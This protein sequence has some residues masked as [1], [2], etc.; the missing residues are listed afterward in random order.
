MNEN[1]YPWYSIVLGIPKC[2]ND[3]QTNKALK[4]NC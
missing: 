1:E 2:K 3:P 4:D